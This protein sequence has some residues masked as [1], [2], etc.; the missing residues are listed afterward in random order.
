MVYDLGSG[1]IT[2]YPSTYIPGADPQVDGNLTVLTS[3]DGTDREIYLFNSAPRHYHQIT[4]NSL[5]DESPSLSGSR[6]AWSADGEIYV[7][8]YRYLG[9]VTPRDNANVSDAPTFSWEGIGYGAFKIQFSTD[10]NFPLWRTITYP[11][12]RDRYLTQAA[13]TPS[14]GMW[15]FL[16]MMARRADCV[17]WRVLGEDAAGAAAYSAARNFTAGE[18]VR[19]RRTRR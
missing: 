6:M 9:L 2:A 18:P 14:R 1:E 8:A 10:S 4:N 12:G 15:F 13:Y 19:L 11:R 16:S 7:A 5:E 3:H 17:Y